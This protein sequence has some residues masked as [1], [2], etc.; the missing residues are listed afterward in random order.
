MY[1]GEFSNTGPGGAV[2]KRVPYTKKLT[3]SE[4]KT[5]M[6]LEYIDAA[7]W[8]LPAPQL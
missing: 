8:L 1:F 3:E 2:D 5:F 7:K 4:A 6:S